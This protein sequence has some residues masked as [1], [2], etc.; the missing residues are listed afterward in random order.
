[1]KRAPY[2]AASEEVIPR[3]DTGPQEG[4]WEGGVAPPLCPATRHTP[5]IALY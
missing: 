1:V 3:A 5:M 4:D 2:L